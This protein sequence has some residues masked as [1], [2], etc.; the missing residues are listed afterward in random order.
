MVTAFTVHDGW[1]SSVIVICVVFY[2]FV[3]F[4]SEVSYQIRFDRKTVTENTKIKFMTDGIL[5]KELQEVC[6]LL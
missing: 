3:F 6:K 2:C 1:P 4:D 5:L